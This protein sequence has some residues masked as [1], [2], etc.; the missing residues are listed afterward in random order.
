MLCGQGL[1]F[2]SFYIF[3]LLFQFFVQ[4]TFIRIRFSNKLN[5]TMTK[6]YSYLVGVLLISIVLTVSS[7]RK[8]SESSCQNGGTCESGKC[9]CPYGFF[10]YFCEWNQTNVVS[11]GTLTFYTSN[12]IPN[13]CYYYSVTLSGVGTQTITTSSTSNCNA[14]GAATFPNLAYGTYY[15]TVTCTNS[16][17]LVTSGN[18]NLNSACVTKSVSYNSSNTGQLSFYAT[19]NSS[20]VSQCFPITVTL[21]NSGGSAMVSGLKTS[22]PTSCT[23][24]DCANFTL[25][26]GTYTATTT[27]NG[28]VTLGTFTVSAGSCQKIQLP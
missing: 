18:I 17:A 1:I 7:C 2:S 20:L 12:S 8:C 23:I 6:F 21:N 3:L 27:C 15:Y 5:G 14:T 22:V 26:V 25:P 24:S 28:L 13:T 9:V 11:K 10:G 4:K 19:G 16:G